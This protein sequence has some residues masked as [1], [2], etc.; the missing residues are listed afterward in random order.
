[1]TRE[2]QDLGV[3]TVHGWFTE[4]GTN[5]I[6]GL[7]VFEKEA[8]WYLMSFFAVAIEWVT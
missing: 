7:L 6:L 5:S 3:D 4:G 1:M 8:A 2:E